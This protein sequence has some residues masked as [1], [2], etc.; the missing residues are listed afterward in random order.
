M[1]GRAPLTAPFA[2][3]SS[4][5]IVYPCSVPADLDRTW[6]RLAGICAELP[7]ATSLV[8]RGNVRGYSVGKAG[9]KAKLFAFLVSAQAGRGIHL[10][11]VDP[12]ILGDAR[13]EES[14]IFSSGGRTNWVRLRWSEDEPSWEE[15]RGLVAESHRLTQTRNEGIPRP[16][17][18][19]D[20]Y[21]ILERALAAAPPADRPDPPYHAGGP[22][23]KLSARAAL[24]VAIWSAARVEALAP[25]AQR[26]EVERV[27]SL[28]RS[29]A[30]SPPER[31]KQAYAD[32]RF[33]VLCEELRE[34]A[35]TRP[36]DSRSLGAARRA[37][38]GAASLCAGK[39]DMVWTNAA[40]AAE[41]TVQALHEHA[42][43]AALRGYLADLDAR[44]L[45]EE[46]GAIDG[47]VAIARVLWRG[48]N[49]KGLPALGSHPIGRRSAPGRERRLRR[50]PPPRVRPTSPHA[51]TSSSSASSY[52]L[53]FPRGEPTRW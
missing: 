1:A 20:V 32:P 45:S 28:A 22:M 41:R 37:A 10:R 17:G 34:A 25:A 2:F 9:S 43:A 13:F 39:P 16:A 49:D 47:G 29:A 31:P 14:R 24:A 15:I 5:G 19:G 18:F 8:V 36:K 53:R 27:L 38:G 7:Q 46:L 51:P 26:A 11:A 23:P 35:R 3:S 12:A 48:A 40:L 4:P 42:D 33:Q 30:R 44:I 6:L 21:P 52:R 50:G